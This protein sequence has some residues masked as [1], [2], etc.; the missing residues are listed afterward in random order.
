MLLGC[1]WFGNLVLDFKIRISDLQ[2]NAKSENGFQRWDICSFIPF[3]FSF[4]FSEKSEKGPK[5]PKKKTTVHEKRYFCK[6]FFGFPNRTVKRKSIKSRFGF[7][8]RNPPWGQICWRWNPFS[9]FAFDCKISNPCYLCYSRILR[10]EP[11][12][13][14]FFMCK[15]QDT[16]GYIRYT[17]LDRIHAIIETWPVNPYWS[18]AL[19]ISK[20][21]VQCIN[22]CSDLVVTRWFHS[23]EV[24][25]GWR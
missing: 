18:S 23:G 3:L 19:V 6:S 17:Y 22:F 9:D 24:R 5:G 20:S 7:R 12:S 13:S 21:Y 25:W 15:F 8:N 4:F 14:Y 11:G 16:I 2:S 10:W 1:V